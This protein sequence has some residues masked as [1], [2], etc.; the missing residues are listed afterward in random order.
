MIDL[1]SFYYKEC[2][3]TA[4]LHEVSQRLTLLPLLIRRINHSWNHLSSLGSIQLN[5]CHLGTYR[6]NQTQQPTLP[7][8]VPIHSWVERS[9]YEKKCLAQGHLS[10]T[11][12]VGIRTHILMLGHGTPCSV[13]ALHARSWHSMLGHGTPCSVMALHARSWH[14]MLGHGTPCSVM[15][16]HARSWH[17]MLG[18]GTPCSVMALH[19]RSWHSM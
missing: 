13:M 19:A 10:T 15:A 16:L 7:S 6:A 1:A 18:H 17:S 14:S 12:A 2:I 11:V 9:N 8:Q 3:F 4:L 5:C